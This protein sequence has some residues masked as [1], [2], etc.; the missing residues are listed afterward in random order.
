MKQKV[1][2]KKNF[3][4]AV[5]QLITD[6]PF[7]LP[8][9][10]LRSI[11]NAIYPYVGILLSAEIL[12]EL[13]SSDANVKRAVSLAVWM[14]VL[15][16]LG[17][18]LLALLNQTVDVMKYKAMKL[19]DARCAMKAWQMD[20]K[21]LGEPRIHEIRNMVGRWH[22][23]HGPVAIAG[24]LSDIIQS[25]F[26][27]GISLAL[28]VE[29]FRTRAVGSGRMVGFL[30]HWSAPIAFL[31]M[32]AFTIWYSIWSYAKINKEEYQVQQDTMQTNNQIDGFWEA[33]CQEYEKGKDLRLFH[34]Q[35]TILTK[36]SYLYDN[37]RKRYE[38]N[39]DYIRRKECWNRF[40]YHFFNMLVYLFVGLKACFG[41]VGVGSI[42]KYT[43]MVSQLGDGIISIFYAFSDIHQNGRYI[44]DYYEYLDVENVTAK[45][46]LPVTQEIQEHYELEFRN[47]TFSYPGNSTPSLVKINCKLRH[48]EKIAVVGPNGSGK[49]T[50]IKLLCRLYDPQEG[51]ILLNGVDIREYRYDE[52]LKLFSTVFQDFQLFAFLLGENVAAD[53]TFEEEKA[54]NALISAGFQ[55][56]LESLPDG[57]NTEL[58]NYFSDEGVEL[59]GGEK[60]KVAVARCLYKDAP[61]AVLDEPTAALDPIAEADL[62]QRMNQFVEKKGAIYISHRL[63]SCHFCDRILVFAEGKLIQEGTHSE[64]LEQKGLYERMWSAQVK[65]YQK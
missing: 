52:Y 48:G 23:A 45:G 14:V 54:R 37:M 41:A 44:N 58:F 49:S 3:I 21:M 27:I 19:V 29:F 53:G 63:S 31:A 42:L 18:L 56:R 8:L 57:L 5:H 11:L 28:A 15:N 47:V 7:L 39:I 64:L 4:R 36:L 2:N 1:K 55:E 61:Y 34:A 43:G 20:Y 62:Y 26:S 24:Q 40:F 32:F 33:C 16:Y 60:Q 35:K 38:N 65:Y 12:N 30:N 13:V 50:F 46:G 17:Q 10:C 22:Y 25:G 59:S 51:Q 6:V 9:T